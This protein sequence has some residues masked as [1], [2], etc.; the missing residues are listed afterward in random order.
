[1]PYQY[2]VVLMSAGGVSIV[3]HHET[4]QEA[5]GAAEQYNEQLDDSPP[6]GGAAPLLRFYRAETAEGRRLSVEA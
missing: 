3:S 6:N 4:A 1:M 2:R 5:Q